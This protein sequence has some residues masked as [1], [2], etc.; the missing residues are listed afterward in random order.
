ML[1][2]EDGGATHRPPLNDFNTFDTFGRE[3]AW[4][5][6]LADGCTGF[7]SVTGGHGVEYLAVTWCWEDDI[8]EWVAPLHT[9]M[10]HHRNKKVAYRAFREMMANPPNEQD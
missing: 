3:V 9:G 7:Y 6:I 5:L 8:E 10:F 1:D 4:R 2:E